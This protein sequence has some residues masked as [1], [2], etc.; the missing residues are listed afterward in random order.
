MNATMRTV[1]TAKK[2]D[3]QTNL[4]TRL[5]AGINLKMTAS[6]T[7]AKQKTRDRSIEKVR[8]SRGF[9][10]ASQHSASVAIIAVRRP[11]QELAQRVLN[12]TTALISSSRLSPLPICSMSLF[13]R[14]DLSVVVPGSQFDCEAP[15]TIQ[16]STFRPKKGENGRDN[17]YAK[18]DADKSI[19]KRVNVSRWPVSLQEAKIKGQRYLKA[20]VRDSIA[21]RSDPCCQAVHTEYN[22]EECSQ[23][24]VSWDHPDS[25]K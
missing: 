4:A 18:D 6:A 3:M 24:L 10:P 17:A 2:I 12:C 21:A 11:F 22:Q 7:I 25:R 9:F 19:P 16:V 23:C 1:C 8:T 14:D 5:R 15:P 13:S 20:H